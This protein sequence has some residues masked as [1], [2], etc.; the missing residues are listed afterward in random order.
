VSGRRFGSC[1]VW[2]WITWR[3]HPSSTGMYF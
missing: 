1:S 2:Q 3:F